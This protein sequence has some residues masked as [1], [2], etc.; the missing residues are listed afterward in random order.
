MTRI[1]MQHTEHMS[2]HGCHCIVLYHTNVP[3]Y[4]RYVI[5]RS[6]TEMNKV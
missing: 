1:Q 4:A 5:S 3:L 6:L 2:G